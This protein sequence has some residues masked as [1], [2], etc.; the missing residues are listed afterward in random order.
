ICQRQ[1]RFWTVPI[2]YG[3]AAYELV[4]DYDL[5][6]QPLSIQD[7]VD[8]SSDG[9]FSRVINYLDEHRGEGEGYSTTARTLDLIDGGLSRQSDV[10]RRLGISVATLRRRL[11]EEGVNFRDLLLDTRLR[12]A[13]GMLKRGC[14]VAQTTELL[15]Y[16]DIRAFNR[17]FKRW[18]GVTPAAFAQDCQVSRELA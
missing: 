13:E 18:K 3:G 9:L 16:S 5:A 8:L 11:G 1:N 6:C 14:S 2:E 10:A 4:Y 17:A 7:Q 15:D 12:Q